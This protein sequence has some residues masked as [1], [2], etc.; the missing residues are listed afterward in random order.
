VPACKGQ[1]PEYAQTLTS[2]ELAACD[3]AF[4]ADDADAFVV[5]CATAS[6]RLTIE[7]A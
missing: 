2:I 6:F 1:L 7:P 5:R 4:V 3:R